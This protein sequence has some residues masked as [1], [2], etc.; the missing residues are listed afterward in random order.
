MSEASRV[1]PDNFRRAETH[2]Y[3]GNFV[4]DGG[5]GKFAHNREPTPIDRQMVV[6]MNRDTLYSS[7]VFDLDEG[8]V[9]VTLPDAGKRFMSMQ[10]WDEEQYC[11]LVVYGG[12]HTLTREK[13]GSRYVGAAVRTL[14][15]P[16]NPDDIKQVHALQDGIRVEQKAPGRF[17]VPGWDPESQKKVREALEMLGMTMPDTHRTFGPRGEVD[18]VRHLIGTAIG[19]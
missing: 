10:V 19:W 17:E 16:G 5:F 15:D 12:S 9:T 1:T 18:P 14:V 13:I 11:P 4:K 7:A 8:P 6:R 2:F 3:F